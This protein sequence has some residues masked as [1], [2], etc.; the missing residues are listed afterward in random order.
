M[1]IKYITHA[2]LLVET[3]NC[4]ILT[5]PWLVGPSW[6]GTL[7]HFP[8]HNFTPKNLPEPDIIYFSHGHDDH[9]HEDTIKKFPRSW[10]KKL[11]IAPNFKEKWWKDS[12]KSKFE[13]IKYLN[14][15]EIFKFDK[16]L[17]LQVFLNDRGDID[18][19]IKIQSA[20]KTCFLQTDNQMSV[21]EAERISQLG[22][23][24]VA[25]M[26]PYLTGIWPA[27]YKMKKNKMIKLGKKKK[28]QSLEYC[29]SL[30]KKLKP[31][32]LIPYAC[33]VSS[34]GKNYYA[35]FIHN[36][37]KKDFTNFVKKKNLK[38]ES[39]ILNPGDFIKFNNSKITKKISKY[40]FNSMEFTKFATKNK[41]DLL[42]YQK[43]EM[44]LPNLKE[45][46]VINNFV[47]K[48]KL[49]LKKIK[50]YNFKAVISIKYLNQQNS[51]I[52]IN[53][54]NKSVTNDFE[55]KN[56]YKPQLTIF[57]DFYKIANLMYKKYSMNFL[58]FH[59]GAITCERNSNNLS[60]NERDFWAWIYNLSF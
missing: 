47:N 44:T 12:L 22:S 45:D 38:T 60:N 52:I 37:S 51:N 7:W 6:G 3:N 34:L 39:L 32:Y 57:I 41:H 8:T 46:V 36:S 21:K 35:N 31:K 53:F 14:H 58:T 43:K 20:N 59:N 50:R 28:N 27:F 30:I 56:V 40:K 42:R 18:S 25:F 15:N 26:M 54:Q 11:I 1:K 17:S 49:G 55:I 2:C 48:I 33:D 4:K 19:S 5:D 10:F 16:E 9:F 23:I 24:D 13:N 29:C